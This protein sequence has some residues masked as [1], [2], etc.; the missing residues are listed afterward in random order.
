[1]PTNNC[2]FDSYKVIY[3]GRATKLSTTTEEP[4]LYIAENAESTFALM[5]KSRLSVC[6]YIIYRTESPE[7]FILEMTSGNTFPI[8]TKITTEELDIFLY[9]NAKIVYVERHIRRQIMSLCHHTRVRQCKI[10]KDVLSNALTL[11]TQFADLFAYAIIKKPGYHA[12]VY[13]GN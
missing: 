6:G 3:E 13:Q 1:M 7:V 5:A 11:S 10:E 9:I 2:K 12:I 4:E 8:K